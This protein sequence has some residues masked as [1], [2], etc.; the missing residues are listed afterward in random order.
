VRRYWRAK[1]D[2][3]HTPIV[4]AVRAAGCSVAETH[5]VGSGFPDLVVGVPFGPQ[6]GVTVLLEV[7]RPGR[8]KAHGAS[9]K[10]TAARQ[11]AFAESW[12]GGPI[13]TVSSPEEALRALGLTA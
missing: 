2:G 4:Q 7:K 5:A 11:E 9:E 10:A 6:A 3:S 13:L 12:R 8:G 1:R